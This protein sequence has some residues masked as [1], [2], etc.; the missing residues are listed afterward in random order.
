MEHGCPVLHCIHKSP[1]LVRIMS[2]MIPNHDVPSYSFKV[3]YY[4]ILPY[5]E[6][7]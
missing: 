7:L 5:A 2:Q 6:D 3:N 1:P 4:I